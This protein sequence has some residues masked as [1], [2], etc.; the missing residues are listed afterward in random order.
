MKKM[1]R[2]TI[3]DS[4]GIYSITILLPDNLDLKVINEDH[5]NYIVK[6]INKQTKRRRK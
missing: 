2:K 1:N 6:V 5:C 3:K 4:S